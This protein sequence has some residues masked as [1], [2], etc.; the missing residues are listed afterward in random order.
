MAIPFD[1]RLTLRTGT[2]YYFR[3]RELSSGEPHYFV[4]LNAD[5]LSQRVILMSVFTSKVDKQE[6]SIARS[7]HP[8]E[9]LIK[10]GPAEYPELTKES[11]VNCNKVFTKPL[12]ELISLWPRL[13]KKPI[14]L[15]TEI[16]EKILAGVELSPEVAE[17]EKALIRSS[18]N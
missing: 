15:P 16:L 11:C 17:E 9:T 10:L 1:L 13:E 8:K 6:R 5:P 2:V 12:A 4:V 7:G 14:D 3:H 18:T